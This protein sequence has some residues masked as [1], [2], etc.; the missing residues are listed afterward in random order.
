MSI[1]ANAKVER[2]AYAEE[3]GIAEEGPHLG[4]LTG[5]GEGGG[6][7]GVTFMKKLVDVFETAMMMDDGCE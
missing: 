5:S 2:K 3:E 4:T 7:S 1:L 6:W